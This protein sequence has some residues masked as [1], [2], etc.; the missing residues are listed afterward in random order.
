[1]NRLLE[2]FEGWKNI[3]FNDLLI[4]D[5]AKRRIEICVSCE[6]LNKRNYCDLCYC[7]MPAKTRSLKSKCKIGKW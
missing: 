2:I 1:M 3:V 4:E 7:Y 5:E 6:F